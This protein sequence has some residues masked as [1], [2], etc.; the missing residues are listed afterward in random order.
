MLVVPEGRIRKKNSVTAHLPKGLEAHRRSK[1]P[2]DMPITLP[3]AA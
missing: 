3:L 2:P 1:P